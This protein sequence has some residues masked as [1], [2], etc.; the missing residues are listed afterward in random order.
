[1]R[2]GHF[3]SLVAT[4]LGIRNLVFY[5]DGAGAVFDHLLGQQVRCFLVAEPGIDISDDGYNMGLEA[6]YAVAFPAESSFYY[7]RAACNGSGSHNFSETYEQHVRF[8]C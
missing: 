2:H 4:L 7:F 1:M 6:I 5:L 3:S 8:G